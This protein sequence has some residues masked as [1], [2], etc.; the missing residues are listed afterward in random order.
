MLLGESIEAMEKVD[1]ISVY[2]RNINKDNVEL[3]KQGKM[4]IK[5]Y[6]EFQRN[7]FIQYLVDDSID[8][9]IAIK[10]IET[11][12]K[13]CSNFEI[14]CKKFIDDKS[15]VIDK[16]DGR[17]ELLVKGNFQGYRLRFKKFLQ[18]FYEIPKDDTL[19]KKLNLNV[20]HVYNKERAGDFFVR[21]VLLEGKINQSW[22]NSYERIYTKQYKSNNCEKYKDIILLDYATVLKLLKFQP[23]EK[24]K[25]RSDED[26]VTLAEYYYLNLEE[27]TNKN[28]NFTMIKSFFRAELNYLKNNVWNDPLEV[29]FNNVDIISLDPKLAFLQLEEHFNKLSE[30]KSTKFGYISDDIE[31]NCKTDKDKKICRKILEDLKKSIELNIAEETQGILY[32]SQNSEHAFI[33]FRLNRDR[34]DDKKQIIH[35]IK[36]N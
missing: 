5:K 32:Y 25:I 12:Y 10:D 2:E 29:Q 20:D 13:Y 28:L 22:G 11:L 1:A 26:I 15:Y 6:L 18:Q 33:I 17:Y 4:D 24:K 19:Y 7:E 23:F 21:L 3:I 9:I 8:I 31:F 35:L 36:N 27:L 30:G 16:G 14:S 34:V